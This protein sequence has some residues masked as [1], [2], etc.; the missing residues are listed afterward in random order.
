MSKLY[1]L[2]IGFTL[3]AVSLLAQPANNE[4]PSYNGD[5]SGRRYSPMTKIND[6]NVAG[7]S[8]AWMYRLTG[9]QGTTMPR[10]TP[11][12]ADGVIYL[13]S[14]DNAVAI[15]AHTGRELWHYVWPSTGAR[16]FS[17]RGMGM[18]GNQV[19]F[20]TPDCR[21]VALSK[22]EGKLK[23]S[24]VIADI[25]QFYYCSVAPVVVGNHVIAGVS[26]DDLDIPGFIE[27]HDP[28]TGDLQWK[29]YT[30]PMKKG[31][32][33]MD[34]WPNEDMASHG[35]GMTWQPITYDPDLK[36]IYVTT[37][38]P[39]P[40]IANSNRKG[41]NLYTGSI[42]AVSAET[43]KMV[44]Y[45]QVSPHDTH[46]WDATQAAVLFDATING[47]PRKLLSMAARN[48]RFVTLDRATGKTIVSV[49]YVKTNWTMGNDAKGQPIPNPAKNPSLAGTLV[50]PNQGGATNW[51]PPAYNPQTGL[52]YVNANRAFSV[53]YIY[54]GS[55]NPLG[56]GG[57]DR[58]GWSESGLEAIDPKTGQIKW[59][60]KWEG[61]NNSG[62]LTTA[63]NLIFTG[64]PGSAIA[65]L[66]ATTGEPL[67]HARLLSGVSMPP[68][69]WELDGTQYLLVGAGDTLYAFAQHVK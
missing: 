18:D 49:D 36:M 51:Y 59:T 69:T 29:F 5:L 43:G 32:P 30:V 57:N 55:D 1:T 68:T 33:G 14:Q 52:F 67:W 13:S 2:A 37:G 60:H 41:D 47:Q 62:L 54:D 56:W 20:E 42:C 6:K 19:F 63:G 7:L 21:L 17:N 28:E 39:Q 26:G 22:E 16:H 24:K 8:L 25:D 9:V 3:G 45:F 50:S 44:W 35:G 12:M 15:D 66:N 48:G 38:N 46:D 40:V 31:D 61:G 23:W 27:A 4:W 53:Y 58:G 64:A 34:S 11:L 65:A 10:A